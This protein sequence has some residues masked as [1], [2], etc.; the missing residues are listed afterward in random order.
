MIQAGERERE[1]GH[2]LVPP[3]EMIALKVPRVLTS[4]W[5]VSRTDQEQMA[6][7]RDIQFDWRWERWRRNL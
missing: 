5:R 6:R 7:A 2:T 4:K 1:T 3:Q